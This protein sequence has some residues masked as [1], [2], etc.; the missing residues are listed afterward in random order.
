[1]NL[2]KLLA[3][4]ARR[5]VPMIVVNNVTY[6]VTGYNV[7]IGNTVVKH[8]AEQRGQIE[9]GHTWQQIHDE[10]AV[11][12]AEYVQHMQDENILPL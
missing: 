11:S 4:A 7:A 12:E 5:G 6:N 3:E 1:M 10:N 9:S 8:D 2:E